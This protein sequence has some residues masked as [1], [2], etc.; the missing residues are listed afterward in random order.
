MPSTFDM[1][2]SS[3]MYVLNNNGKLIKFD[4]FFN[5]LWEVTPPTIDTDEGCAMKV[6]ALGTIIL[7]DVDRRTIIV[8][9]SSDGTELFS[10]TGRWSPTYYQYTNYGIDII[11]T[12][13]KNVFFITTAQRYSRYDYA[14]I[15]RVD[16]KK[17]EIKNKFQEKSKDAEVEI[18]KGGQP[19]YPYIISME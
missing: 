11:P 17:D 6:T 3:N 5:K 18:Y 4:P 15:S 8:Y 10:D 16:I 14:Q 7:A 1:D 9:D 19:L 13:D 2:V 12:V